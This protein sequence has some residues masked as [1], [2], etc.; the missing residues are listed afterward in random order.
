MTSI[1]AYKPRCFHFHDIWQVDDLRLKTYTITCSEDESI[2]G[3]LLANA[4]DYIRTVLPTARAEEG[5]DHEAGYVILHKG[6]MATWLLIHWWAH[7]D[8][9]LRLLAFA[10]LGDTGFQSA[11]HRR[12]H[13]CVWEHVVID[14]ERDA[15][16]RTAMATSSDL[17]G[18]FDDRL[19]DGAY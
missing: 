4:L 19:N 6:E 13:A 9:A 17:N 3:D 8:I 1:S 12:F 7:S 15:W 18:Y 10:P 14:H 2:E 16:V 5:T 11:D